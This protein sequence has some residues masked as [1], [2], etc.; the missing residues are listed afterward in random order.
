ML[1]LHLLSDFLDPAVHPRVLMTTAT[2]AANMNALA[3]QFLL[4]GCVKITVGEK[5]LSAS[6][7]VTQTVEV[8]FNTVLIL[9]LHHADSVYSVFT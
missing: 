9:F 3:M 1:N 4:P 6:K 5:D 7:T 2:W 8:L